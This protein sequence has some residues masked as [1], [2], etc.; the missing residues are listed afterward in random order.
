VEWFNVPHY[1]NTG[2]ATLEVNLYEETNDIVFQYMDVD[3]GSASYNNGASATVGLENTSGT[4]G[5]EFSCNSPSINNGMAI[6]FSPRRCPVTL[7][8]L[9]SFEAI[10][11]SNK[12]ILEWTTESEI[13]NAGFNIYRAESEDG[14]YVKINPTLIPAEGNGTSGATYKYVD[15]SV[16][17][18]ITYYYKLEDIDLKGTSTMHRA[19]NATPRAMYRER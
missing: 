5:T 7:I 10:P 16:R 4:A 13:N 8:K 1:S 14:E 3:F 12:V 11:A 15:D 17:N 19:V 6:R 2:N 18:R 9:T